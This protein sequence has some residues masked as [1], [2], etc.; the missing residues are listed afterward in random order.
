MKKRLLAGMIAV[1]TL[2]GIS[3]ASGVSSEAT[4][5]KNG[6]GKE[7][8][9][10][11]EVKKGL[12]GLT[13]EEIT[14]SQD[15]VIKKISK[16]V[17]SNINVSTRYNVLNNAFVAEVNEDAIEAIRALPE[18][19]SVSVDK[20]HAKQDVENGE[21]YSAKLTRSVT[22]DV[23]ELEENISAKTMNKPSTTNDGEGTVIA[24]LDNEFYLRGGDHD[25]DPKHENDDGSA[26][27]HVVFKD[28]DASV[29]KRFTFD[30]LTP[31]IENEDDPTNAQRSATKKTS[32]TA[33]DEG[34]LYYNSKVP[35]Y[36]DYGG[37]SDS[38]G[39]VG[40][41]DFDVSSTLTY[42]GS[43]VASIASANANCYKGIAPKAQLACMKVFTTYIA[44]ETGEQMGFGTS[45]GAY[46]SAILSALED[47]IR[48]D[49]DGINMSLGSDLGDFDE[50]TIGYKTLSKLASESS[51]MTAISAGNSGKASFSFS[52]GYG[53]WTTDMVETGVLG[54]YANNTDSCIIASGQ[55]TQ[56]YFETAI[57]TGG[58]NIAYE[59]QIVN[60]E[61]QA[62][63]YPADKQFWLK[64]LATTWGTDIGWVYVP[65]FG[66]GADYDGLDVKNKVAV[67]NRGS[68]NF[69]DKYANAKNKG[70][71]GLIIINN[72]PT[73]NEFNFRCSFGDDFS[74]S[75]PCALVLYKDKPIF[76]SQRLG[77]FKFITKQVS[78]NDLARTIST[79][80]SDGA[81]YNYDLKPDVTT[82]GE[83]IRGALPP[84]KKEDRESTP[85]STYAYLSGTSMA[86][87]NYAGAQSLL[88][89][90]V[91]KSFVED[92]S[93][94]AV[95]LETIKNYRKTVDMRL[96]STAN[97]MLD[98]TANG[99]D[100]MVNYTSPRIQGA[101]MVDLGK[102]YN[103]NI[104][105]EGI[106]LEGNP[107]GKSKICLGNSEE[108]AQGKLDLSFIAHNEGADESFVA[109][110]TVMRPAVIDANN[111]IPDEYSFNGE[112]DDVTEVPGLTYYTEQF[113]P[114]T[115]QTEIVKKTNSATCKK[116]EVI[117]VTKPIEYYI[118]K[119]DYEAKTNVKTFANGYY[120][121]TASVGCTWEDLPSSKYQS[122][123]D[124][125]ILTRT[126]DVPVEIPNGTTTIDLP[127]I[128]LSE[129]SKKEILKYYPYGCA[130]EGYVELQ[131]SDVTKLSMPFLGFYSGAD[132]TSR[133]NTTLEDAAVVEPFT[134]E[135]D[136]SKIYPSDLVN[137]IAKSLVGKDKAE[138]GSTWT[139]G[140]AESTLAIDTDK[141]LTN[142]MNFESMPGWH[143][144]GS[145]PED[146]SYFEDPGKNIY[147]GNPN[148]SNTMIIQQYVMRSVKDNYFTIKN[149]KGDV[150]YKSVLEDSLFREK[151]LYKSH[152]DASYLSAGYV[153]HRAWAIIPLYDELTGLSFADG[154]YE[155]EFNYQLA[156]NDAW[157]KKAYNFTIDATAPVVK[158]I[159]EYADANGVARVRFEIEDLKV[160]K[161]SLGYGLVDVT[162]DKDKK[163]YVIDETKEEINA[164]IEQLGTL[165]NGQKRLTLSVTDAAYGE[166][167]AIIH[168]FGSTYSNYVIAQGYGLKS[169]QDFIKVGTNIKWYQLKLGEEET[170]FEQKNFITV[171]TNI[172][173]WEDDPV[174]PG[175]TPEPEPEKKSNTGLIVG[176]SVGGGVLVVGAG[177]GLYFFFRK[178]KL[179]GK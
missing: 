137:D 133:E 65:G 54:S 43:H 162:Y 10:I 56:V 160:S 62:E 72:D 58:K 18:V 106:D 40:P 26:W 86:A 87:P 44:D 172:A 132:D 104:Y 78:E 135:K 168:F 69:S 66:T 24:I 151:Q 131:Q 83:S 173:K 95:E 170:E 42:H 73:A 105:L 117:K 101:G 77:T 140:Y 166:S 41:T 124:V 103:S 107:I 127:E 147:V 29:A 120:V 144:A 14:K 164:I 27:G 25:I 121:N 81:R 96:M 28:L 48:L 36:F 39:K 161:A 116:N 130:I 80:S 142:D 47:C 100:G 169:N 177:V 3:V 123:Q 51:I 176:L 22:E 111:V 129:E 115:K 84:Q 13:S 174:P 108:V 7:T 138:F 50:G 102:A 34:S 19:A 12:E 93:V 68:I 112:I 136:T 1:M 30:N 90:K 53:N 153:A 157:V 158:S 154:T 175:P 61:G 64:D 171:Y 38:Y 165:S 8:R 4:A 122:I 74:P 94:S 85:Y 82:P 141:V 5:S 109:K 119:A 76:E 32:A 35:F 139:F 75:M 152:V 15:E 79:F 179:G 88:L 23:G 146:E 45:T 148:T 2:G 92:G 59:D 67:V 99:E 55:P 98:A 46:D 33:G 60:R 163:V 17:T 110:V 57:L 150:V 143:K 16:N 20:M 37:E 52:G 63:D 21:C 49:V 156:Y 70:A 167:G 145:N 159:E 155:L 125:V 11:V 9:I 113:N 128:A 71:I 149:A 31:I 6:S 126:F 134:F 97:P 178:R 118:T 89:S 91:S 114:D